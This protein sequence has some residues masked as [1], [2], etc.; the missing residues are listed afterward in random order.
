V[1]E[2]PVS[3]PV[4]GHP[5]IDEALAAVVLGDDVHAHHDAL[6]TALDV[7]QRVLNEPAG[8]DGR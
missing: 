5:A 6:A 2:L 8:D 3:P 7:L 1:T 4:T